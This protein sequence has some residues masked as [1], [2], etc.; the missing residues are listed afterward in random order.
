MP[1]MRP[2]EKVLSQ[3]TVPSPAPSGSTRT[4]RAKGGGV[5]LGG[6]SLL[7]EPVE[8]PEFAST[9]SELEGEA[10]VGLLSGLVSVSFYCGTK[11]PAT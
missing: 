7:K 8:I 2:R 9:A 10:A 5:F 11:H 6:S 4:L 1:T 3:K